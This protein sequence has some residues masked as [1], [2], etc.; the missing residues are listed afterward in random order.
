MIQNLL[1]RNAGRV[2]H[3]RNILAQG[4]FK[5]F[6]HCSNFSTNSPEAAALLC[7]RIGASFTSKVIYSENPGPSTLSHLPPA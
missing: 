5:S 6:L 1:Y 7:W 4:T 2:I 3:W